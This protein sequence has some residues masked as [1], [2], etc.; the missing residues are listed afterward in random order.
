MSRSRIPACLQVHLRRPEATT[1]L[2]SSCLVQRGWCS[3]FGSP[4]D[5]V[6]R[7]SRTRVQVCVIFL[8]IQF[9]KDYYG[10]CR[11]TE[12]TGKDVQQMHDSEAKE[13]ED[14]SLQ[15]KRSNYLR[16]VKT[17]VRRVVTLSRQKRSQRGGRHIQSV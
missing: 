3:V 13:E 12:R 5:G 4:G 17:S 6:S 14:E 16:P 2:S 9:Y 11:M 1:S 10:M 7:R 15:G 8:L